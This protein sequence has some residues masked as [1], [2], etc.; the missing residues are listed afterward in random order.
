MKHAEYLNKVCPKAFRLRK[1][2]KAAIILAFL[3]CI[4]AVLS[5]FTHDPKSVNASAIQIGEQITYNTH[6]NV[7][8][9]TVNAPG[10][11][12]DKI[13]MVSAN[14][15]W[16]LK[17]FPGQKTAQL[18]RWNGTQ[19]SLFTTLTHTQDIVRGDISMSSVNDGWVVLGG[20][21]GGT[22]A[23]SVV[24]RWDGSNW[25]Y[26]TTI[27]D[28]NAISLASLETL[29]ANSVWALGGG[30]FWSTL[31]RWDGT[32]WHYAGKTPGGVW[33]DNDLAMISENDGWAVGF[34]GHIAHWNGTT[35]S[36]VTSPVTSSLNAVAMINANDGW[37]VGDNGIILR[38]NG[39]NWSQADS[40]TSANLSSV[41]MVSANEGW[42]IGGNVLLHWNGQEWSL[43]TKPVNDWFKDIHML[44]ADDGWVVGSNNVLHYQVI[45]PALTI[46]YSSGAPGSYFSVTGQHFPP[47]ET[48]QITVNGHSLG[49]VQVDNNGD[50]FFLITTA[51]ADEGAY[52]VTASVNPSATEQFVLDANE[53]VRP[54]AGTGDTF[55]VPAGIA[56]TKFVY[57]PA[58]SR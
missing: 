53:P 1:M 17:L 37:A 58:V 55:D 28:L 20:W 21:L 48:A 45:P 19:W 10:V 40:P 3:C 52:F 5:L 42:I 31:Y 9:W 26:F 12:G 14:D 29:S 33:T 49:T 56:M 47:N 50:I 35:W 41:A 23:Q 36:Q 24:Y 44:S 18:F 25:S 34:S 22:P 54:Q 4:V 13:S 27:T 2:H 11:G 46:N 51:N 15:G 43:F 38:W 16:I 30:N 8:A 32:A 57:L 6:S 39:V 7:G